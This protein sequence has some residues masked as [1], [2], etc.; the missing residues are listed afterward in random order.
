MT[1]ERSYKNCK[2]R[3]NPWDRGQKE[4]CLSITTCMRNHGF[5][6]V[7]DKTAYEGVCESERDPPH[8]DNNTQNLYGDSEC[9]SNEYFVEKVKC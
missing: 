4:Y 8:D 9:S 1:K 6:V 7:S 5:P 2:I 3:N